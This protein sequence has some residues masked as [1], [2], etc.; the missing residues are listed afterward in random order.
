MIVWHMINQTNVQIAIK[1]KYT[2]KKFV[3]NN[4]DM[5]QFVIYT[6]YVYGFIIIYVYVLVGGV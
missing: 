4:T 2:Y 5:N 3:N 6:R 1:C